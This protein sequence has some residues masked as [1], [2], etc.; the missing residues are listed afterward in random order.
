MCEP[1]NASCKDYFGSLPPCGP[2]DD[3]EPTDVVEPTDDVEPTIE[4]T[5]NIEDDVSNLFNDYI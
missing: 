2:D 4:L 1:L 5:N 3:V